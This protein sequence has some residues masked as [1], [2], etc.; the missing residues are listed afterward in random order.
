MRRTA[1]TP[2]RRNI[3]HPEMAWTRHVALGTRRE[4]RRI[5]V[6]VWP[7]LS[8]AAGVS[9]RQTSRALDI[10]RRSALAVNASGAIVNNARTLATTTSASIAA[11]F[12]CP[13][14]RDQRARA[15]ALGRGVRESAP[16]RAATNLLY[17]VAHTIVVPRRN[18]GRA[19]A[20]GS[21]PRGP[22]SPWMLWRHGSWAKPQM[23]PDSPLRALRGRPSLLAPA[24]AEP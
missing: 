6:I 19:L 23:P 10:K 9:T 5:A 1:D 3:I 20:A 7:M 12:S 18:L 16:S 22:C 11:A 13:E 21:Q 17:Q 8:S 4:A 24:E 14:S 15:F 2:R